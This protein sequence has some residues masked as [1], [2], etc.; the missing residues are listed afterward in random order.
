MWDPSV[1]DPT[2]FFFLPLLSV[3]TAETADPAHLHSAEPTLAAAPPW[4][5]PDAR[6]VTPEPPPP[7][8]P[9]PSPHRA[10]FKRNAIQSYLYGRFRLNDGFISNSGSNRSLSHLYKCRTPPR[11]LSS[12]KTSPEPSTDELRT[13]EVPAANASLLRT[14]AAFKD[15]T[16]SFLVPLFPFL[17]S[18][19]ELRAAEKPFRRVSG[20]T[21]PRAAGG[22]AAR[23]HGYLP[24]RSIESRRPR[25]D[26]AAYPFARSTVV[27]G[28][29]VF[30]PVHSFY[31]FSNTKIIPTEN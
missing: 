17:A 30:G 31:V 13:P 20:D 4:H 22:A 21:P 15:I 28:P 10:G 9:F 26:G 27:C 11:S 1:S 12:G 16:V 5:H 23:R 3:R 14:T 18:C 24:H 7:L 19:D 25:L 6:C 29:V 2:V 8:F